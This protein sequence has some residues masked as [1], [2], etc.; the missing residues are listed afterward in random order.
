MTLQVKLQGK[1]L[2]FSYNQ[3]EFFE[4]VFSCLLFLIDMSLNH[5]RIENVLFSEM[6]HLK[7]HL[8]AFGIDE[9]PTHKVKSKMMALTQKTFNEIN[10]AL[11]SYKETF[12]KVD[13]L[14]SQKIDTYLDGEHHFQYFDAIV[15]EVRMTLQ[16]IGLLP[17]FFHL[18]FVSVNCISLKEEL[19][20]R[21]SAYLNSLISH[22]FDQHKS[23][24]KGLASEFETIALEINQVV[25]KT[26][27]I[28]V[29][30]DSVKF[31]QDHSLRRLKIGVARCGNRMIH[32][33]NH[34][35]FKDHDIFL[36]CRLFSWPRDLDELLA[37][38]KKRLQRVKKEAE[39]ALA[40]RTSVFLDSVI[41]IENELE[42]F[43]R[44]DPPVLTIEDMKRTSSALDLLVSKLEKASADLKDI[45][46][47]EEHLGW[48][49]TT[50]ESLAVLRQNMDPYHKL[51]HISL[52][53]TV[54]NK[55]WSNG[56]LAGLEYTTIFGEI[57]N[58]YK[59]IYK[60]CKTFSD[61]PGPRR[62]A[63][64]VQ[65]TWLYLEPIFC[66]DDIRRQMAKSGD[67]FSVV[68]STWRGLMSL[69]SEESTVLTVTK[70]ENLLK[71]LQEALHSL[72]DI[73]RGLDE[74]LD[75]K[76]VFFPN[77]YFLS[78]DEL[79]E[80]LSKT[81][82]PKMVEP[83][84][85]RV[86]DQINRLEFSS[87]GEIVAVY[88]S[89]DERI[90][91]YR[92]VDPKESKGMVELWLTEVSDCVTDSLKILLSEAID[93]NLHD[94]SI[95]HIQ[96]YPN[97][98]LL[99]AILVQWT[100]EVERVFS[101]GKD[102]EGLICK[103]E[104]ILLTA[105]NLIRSSTNKLHKANLSNIVIF[106]MHLKS[107]A[108]LLKALN[109][110]S[111]RTSVWLSQLRGYTV[112]GS[113]FV[114]V[115]STE[116]PYGY[117]YTGGS[118]TPVLTSNVMKAIR[119]IYEA[120]TANKGILLYGDI[121]SGKT[122]SVEGAAVF[123]GRS[124]MTYNASVQTNVEAFLNVISGAIQTGSWLCVHGVDRIPLDVLSVV[125]QTLENLFIT[126]QKGLRRFVIGKMEL[127]ITGTCAIIFTTSNW[128]SFSKVAPDCFLAIINKVGIRIEDPP[129]I[130]QSI[131]M[132]KGF[133]NSEKLTTKYFNF[134]RSLRKK[135]KLK[136]SYHQNDLFKVRSIVNRT[137]RCLDNHFVTD[138]P[139]S[140]DYDQEMYFSDCIKKV[141]ISSCI[142]KEV[143]TMQ[144]LMIEYFP[145]L[146]AQNEAGDLSKQ[147]KDTIQDLGLQATTSF[148]EKLQQLLWLIETEHQIIIE[149]PPFSG[150]TS[151][152]KVVQEFLTRQR[153]IEVSAQ[154]IFC[155]AGNLSEVF[156]KFE[157]QEWKDGLLTSC[158]RV[159]CHSAAQNWLILDCSLNSPFH[160]L[161]TLFD[162]SRKYSLCSGE[163][164]QAESGVKIFIE[165][166][167]LD[168]APTGTTSRLQHMKIPSDMISI[169]CL[170]CSFIHSLVSKFQPK[171]MLNFCFSSEGSDSNGASGKD[172]KKKESRF[173]RE[174]AI[175]AKS[176]SSSDSDSIENRR[177]RQGMLLKQIYETRE[178][179][180]YIL[181]PLLAF[182]VNNNLIHLDLPELLLAQNFL[183][184]FENYLLLKSNDEVVTDTWI[185]S[186]FLFSAIY[187][188]G[189]H[190]KETDV[191]TKKV[192]ELLRLSPVNFA[193]NL[194]E[195]GSLFDWTID[196][197]LEGKWIS[198]ISISPFQTIFDDHVINTIVRIPSFCRLKFFFNKCVA[199]SRPLLVFGTSNS[200]KSTAIRYFLSQL[201]SDSYK[202]AVI[203]LTSA[204][205]FD[206]LR[207]EIISYLERRRK[208]TYGPPLGKRFI[209]FL[210]DLQSIYPP[211]EGHKM[212]L[213]MLR[214]WL[215]CGMIFE[216]CDGEVVELVD[217]NLIVSL[218]LPN[219][220]DSRILRFFDFTYMENIEDKNLSLICS[221]VLLNKWNSVSERKC[222]SGI[223]SRIIYAVYMYFQSQSLKYPFSPNDIKR[224]LQSVISKDS[225]ALTSTCNLDDLR[226]LY[227]LLLHEI[228]KTFLLRLPVSDAYLS[229][230][231]SIFHQ[232]T[233][234]EPSTVF[235]GA[236]PPADANKLF[237]RLLFSV[238]SIEKGYKEI[239]SYEEYAV[240][241][242][243]CL[244]EARIK[245]T[246]SEALV[247]QASNVIRT[248]IHQEGHMIII[249]QPNSGKRT[250]V[251][252]AACLL[253][254]NL[255]EIK[256][257]T[258]VSESEW[259]S[260]LKLLLRLAGA[261]GEKTCFLIN[262]KYLFD[263][264][265][266]T[267][268]IIML[269]IYG[270]IPLLFSQEEKMELL[271][272]HQNQRS[273][274]EEKEDST[275]VL[276][277]SFTKHVK[278]N[279]HIVITCS[280]SGW[281]C[282]NGIKLFPQLL[283]R[284]SVYLWQPWKDSSLVFT[285][286]RLI[287]ELEPTL[288]TMWS[289]DIKNNIV[290]AILRIFRNSEIRTGGNGLK[291][292][293]N[294]S[295][296]TFLDFIS[297]FIRILKEKRNHLEAEK[298]RYFLGLELLNTASSQVEIQQ[299]EMKT[300]QPVLMKSSAETEVFMVK[301]E[302]EAISV[303]AEREVVA[304]DGAQANEAAALAQAI[305]DES[306]ADLA[307]AIP[308]LE[309]AIAALDTLRPP[310]ITE[311][312]S[313]KN[314]PSIVRL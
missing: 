204:T 138:S 79:L 241:I 57:E 51:W 52:D 26:K 298:E 111:Q 196:K 284:T 132:S 140:G 263:P 230:I 278:M 6:Q 198:W 178:I 71:K 212:M 89:S 145:A 200:G 95:Y 63:Q 149:G 214:M 74:Y 257:G 231:L 286:S 166:T 45:N 41:K 11:R 303:E 217:I 61:N 129:S 232:E 139:N 88:S 244:E 175:V 98:I 31:H 280:E 131:M 29:L 234:I 302:Q 127:C 49:P 8:S 48:E 13:H 114:R 235:E 289:P 91:F 251:R 189:I 314:P 16:E 219:T 62:V 9:E 247:A 193:V 15:K 44:K 77:F 10:I 56:P 14:S 297:T 146:E 192:K 19:H 220:I 102:F 295:L 201:N 23:I 216:N 305:K 300:L 158:L 24:T 221:S 116:L 190:F 202:S 87:S 292:K 50:V 154:W 66:S 252:V 304:A 174:L 248:L 17:N 239:E 47:N 123:A 82:D 73:Q 291:N 301:L 203:Q 222:L 163:V 69:V 99:L 266:C 223:Y 296:G 258:A 133:L 42:D 156:G 170:C 34:M 92:R 181:Q 255:F 40:E 265:V 83:Y 285:A 171:E 106:C 136:N 161:D 281:I 12:E 81:K 121:G 70:Q 101:E 218:K 269:M 245:L 237:K 113:V 72:Q 224:L 256:K 25:D 274:K 2:Q 283:P 210:E 151:L 1:N 250:S 160:S 18:S 195:D 108:T 38:S 242:E 260:T 32:L 96:K 205:T 262:E 268:H 130:L 39:E 75:K 125:T 236:H 172:S 277:N 84:L 137:L 143:E 246:V 117:E 176:H 142:G 213:E 86:F 199:S 207:R 182:T 188:I 76:R 194:H 233:E 135:L 30:L 105:V 68:D 60:L 306:E 59:I 67:K 168:G 287:E 184:L 155:S 307:D 128:I 78:N 103:Y 124:I 225:L 110:T 229:V 21:L 144:N 22:Q 275:Y 309:A 294:P 227:R 20:R 5:P 185:H 37:V 28:V 215:E 226:Q 206:F 65:S 312:K 187:T 109:V 46:Q 112:D 267:S 54:K 177:P 211:S 271:E 159:P 90:P 27:D 173:K 118:Q 150:K 308:A 55:R 169:N 249:G 209:F 36:H 197:N 7:R 58:M 122:E 186:S 104:S 80:I 311:I 179:F 183:A 208:G 164:I 153:K 254:M 191:F 53:F 33:L 276:N 157:K 97:Q 64:T 4:A 272:L 93:E 180:K 290:I 43:R 253:R 3:D 228:Q 107:S 282:S 119:H 94:I 147:L 148:I 264:M 152:I 243:Q 299:K 35:N 313:L 126:L 240:R 134:Q 293:I 115:G 261:R 238:K 273:Q 288:S 165:T 120:V 141:E 310:D 100:Y 270:E 85:K 259:Q 279:L 167:G 162:S